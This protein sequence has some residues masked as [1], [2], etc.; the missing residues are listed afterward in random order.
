MIDQLIL[1]LT[2]FV[3]ATF[4]GYTVITKVPPTLHTPLMSG[5]NAISGI[6]I[7]GALV[8]AGMADSTLAQGLATGALVLATINVVGGFLV[9]DRMLRMFRRRE[10]P[11][12]ELRRN[13]LCFFARD[14]LFPG[15]QVCFTRR[16]PS[17]LA[18]A[19]THPG[20]FLDRQI[21]VAIGV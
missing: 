4:I 21:A 14:R 20:K 5:P 13:F 1:S 19:A 10:R 3:L 9:T 16:F 8:A 15:R 7:V 17:P 18:A 6:V 12:L 2:V 11:A